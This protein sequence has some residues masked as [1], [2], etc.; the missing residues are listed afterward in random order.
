MLRIKQEADAMAVGIFRTRTPESG[1]EYATVQ[2]GN[3][4]QLESISRLHYELNGYQPP[5][6]TLPD[7]V[8]FDEQKKKNDA[9]AIAETMK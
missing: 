3:S 7:K 1:A 2:Y 5:F 6:N 8:L 4:T 9:Q